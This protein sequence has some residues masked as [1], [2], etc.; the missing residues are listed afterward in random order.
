[1]YFLA[2]AGRGPDRA[3]LSGLLRRNRA[4]TEPVHSEGVVAASVYAGTSRLNG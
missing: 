2:H 4:A 3:S 1:M